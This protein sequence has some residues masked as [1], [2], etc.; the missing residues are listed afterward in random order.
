MRIRP[1]CWWPLVRVV[2]TS[3]LVLPLVGLPGSHPY[4]LPC[5][6]PAGSDLG[7]S[8]SLQLDEEEERRKRRRE[9]NKVA[10][11]RCRNKKKERTE[12][13]QRVGGLTCPRAQWG[14]WQGHIPRKVPWLQAMFPSELA[15]CLAFSCALIRE[16]TGPLPPS[17]E[18]ESGGHVWWHPGAHGTRAG[19]GWRW[20]LGLGERGLILSLPQCWSREYLWECGRGQ[21]PTA[22]W[23]L[24]Q[25]PEGFPVQRP[26]ALSPMTPRQK[27]SRS[28]LLLF[29]KGW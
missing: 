8:F 25:I 15:L 27:N 29:C 14:P 13:L 19:E 12:F 4:L 10:A 3:L 9:K 2:T 28:T 26:E 17:H 6:T 23:P 16:N 7:F 24:A 18:A 1:C 5:P 20:V 21:E 22:C 11:A